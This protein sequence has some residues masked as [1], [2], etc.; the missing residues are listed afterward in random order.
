MKP[1]F[2]AC[3]LLPPMVCALTLEWWIWRLK[4]FR[5]VRLFVERLD[6]DV[7]SFAGLGTL[8]IG[9]LRRNDHTG[10]KIVVTHHLRRVMEKYVSGIFW[11]LGLSNI[12]VLVVLFVIALGRHGVA[13]ASFSELAIQVSDVAGMFWTVPVIEVLGVLSAFSHYRAIASQTEW[14]DSVLE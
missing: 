12:G 14:Y 10:D 11:A 6:Q 13:Q 4:P 3:F 2:L 9:Q 5:L 8:T 1:I 7:V